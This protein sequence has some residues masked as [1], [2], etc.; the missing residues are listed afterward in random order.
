MVNYPPCQVKA[1]SSH[2]INTLPGQVRVTACKPEGIEPLTMVNSRP[3]KSEGIEPFNMVNSAMSS[4][5]LV[6]T[7]DQHSIGSSWGH[8]SQITRYQA[9][10]H[11]GHVSQ[12]VPNAKSHSLTSPS[13]VLGLLP[14]PWLGSHKLHGSLLITPDWRPPTSPHR[15]PIHSHNSSWNNP[16]Q[17]QRCSS[18]PRSHGHHVMNMQPCIYFH[19]IAC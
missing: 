10:Q 11:G 18:L 9:L 6:L 15:I 14:Q 19:L 4:Q 17:P 1:M 2:Q 12:S 16:P 8:P 13:P 5:G 3:C 7:P